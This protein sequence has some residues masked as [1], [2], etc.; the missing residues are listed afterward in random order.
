[1]KAEYTC[2]CVRGQGHRNDK[3]GAHSTCSEKTRNR[4]NV[5]TDFPEVVLFDVLYK[6]SHE[7]NMKPGN[8]LFSKLCQNYS[9][10]FVGFCMK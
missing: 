5:T 3:L 4:D 2:L 6:S 10:F 9:I 7:A 1:M 8:V